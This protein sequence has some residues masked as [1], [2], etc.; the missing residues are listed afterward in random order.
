MNTDLFQQQLFAKDEVIIKN[1]FFQ[2][3]IKRLLDIFVS[4][5]LIIITSPILLASC[6]AIKQDSSGSPIYK[7]VRLGYKEKEF[8]AY[9]LRTMYEHSSEGN[10]KAPKDGDT[11]VTKVGRILRKTS[12]D[13]LP[14]LINV[15][16]GDMSILGPRAVPKKELQL[17][18]E[19]MLINNP[20]KEE[21]FN[22][23]MHVRMLVKP[24]ISGMAQAF[25]RSSLSVEAATGYDVYYAINYSLWLDV[26]IFFKTIDTILFQ[27]GVN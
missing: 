24:G 22:Q 27:R 15:F 1:H 4:T 3:K 21:L 14:Q 13:E 17:R 12:I 23:A 2:K 11:R 10:L 7:Q 25:G 5:I 18:C 19:K 6:I 20:D 26:K 8:T 9:K 16:I